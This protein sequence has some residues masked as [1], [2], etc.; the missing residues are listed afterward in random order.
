MVFN[1]SF[2][3]ALAIG[4][5]YAFRTLPSKLVIMSIAEPFI[6]KKCDIITV[7]I[8]RLIVKC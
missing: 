6:N 7:D 8:V 1:N 3:F 4:P 2:H 5:L